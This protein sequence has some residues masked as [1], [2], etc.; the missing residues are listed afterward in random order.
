MQINLEPRARAT[1]TKVMRMATRAYRV[2]ILMAG[3]AIWIIGM[4]K[5]EHGCNGHRRVRWPPPGEERLLARRGK[6]GIE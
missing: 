2:A 3:G 1:K 6:I 5:L 4:C